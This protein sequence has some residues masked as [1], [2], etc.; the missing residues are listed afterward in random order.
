MLC[1]NSS[2]TSFEFSFVEIEQKISCRVPRVLSFDVDSACRWAADGSHSRLSIPRRCRHSTNLAA[3]ARNRSSER[4]LERK[5]VESRVPTSAGNET[6]RNGLNERCWIFITSV[7]SSLHGYRLENCTATCVALTLGTSRYTRTCL[8]LCT[9]ICTFIMYLRIY[10]YICVYIYICARVRVCACARSCIHMSCIRWRQSARGRGFE[11]DFQLFLPARRYPAEFYAS[12]I[13]HVRCP[14]TIRSNPDTRGTL[15][16]RNS[17][18]LLLDD[19]VRSRLVTLE[20][21][22]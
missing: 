9:Y 6:A 11:V 15:V 14:T 19:H 8:F 21:S 5:M 10:V 7:Q 17:S 3:P 12:I 1:T 20:R 13:C 22:Y 2:R 16:K 4:V 18:L